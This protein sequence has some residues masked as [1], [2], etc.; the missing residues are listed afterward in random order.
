MRKI[1]ALVTHYR[2]AVVVV[3]GKCPA[4]A[5]RQASI[6]PRL[7]FLADFGTVEGLLYWGEREMAAS[8]KGIGSTTNGEPVQVFRERFVCVQQYSSVSRTSGSTLRRT[9]ASWLWL[10]QPLVVVSND[11]NS[12]TLT[13]GYAVRHNFGVETKRYRNRRVHSLGEQRTNNA[14]RL[15]RRTVT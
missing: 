9:T 1:I 7:V 15:S 11:C 10:S 3:G 4:Y 13:H 5:E 2:T 8:S 14:R 12:W 6:I